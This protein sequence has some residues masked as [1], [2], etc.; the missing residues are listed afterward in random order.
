M[1]DHTDPKAAGQRAAVDRQDAKGVDVPAGKS[2]R[3]ME[4]EDMRPARTGRTGR[5]GRTE[6]ASRRDER[7]ERANDK[8]EEDRVVA[9]VHA[10]ASPR[11]EERG[12]RPIGNT[13]VPVNARDPDTQ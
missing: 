8:G 1:S 2:V 7:V 10:D 13:D 11:R 5:T 3:E 12:V 4:S 6:E 9:T